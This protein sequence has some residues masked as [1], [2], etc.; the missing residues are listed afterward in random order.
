MNGKGNGERKKRGWRKRTD[1]EIMRKWG[2]KGTETNKLNLI[3]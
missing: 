1:S 3:S 2:W